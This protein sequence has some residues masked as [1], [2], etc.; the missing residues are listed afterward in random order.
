[1]RST[2]CCVQGKVEKKYLG[3]NLKVPGLTFMFSFFLDK[4]SSIVAAL[5]QGCC[6]LHYASCDSSETSNE[7]LLY[8]WSTSTHH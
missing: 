6:P 5:V 2:S 4:N 8:F 7:Q 1:M 3:S